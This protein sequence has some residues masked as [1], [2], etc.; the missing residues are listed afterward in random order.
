MRER[1][2]DV[3]FSAA[4]DDEGRYAAERPVRRSFWSRLIH[5]HLREWL[6][7]GGVLFAVGSVMV[8]ALFLQTGPHP[9]PRW[10]PCL[11]RSRHERRPALGG[12]PRPTDR[13]AMT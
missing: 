3:N 4:A 1:V 11:A 6:M 2:V 5:W 9:A 7:V 10:P 13:R 8:N 12:P